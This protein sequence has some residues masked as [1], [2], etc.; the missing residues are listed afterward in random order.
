MIRQLIVTAD[1]YGM[2]ETVNQAIEECLA[3]GVVK[4]TCVMINMP[5]HSQAA[6]LRQRFPYSSL[7]IH[8]TLTEGAPIL[9]PEHL[10]S[11][12]G[13]DGHFRSALELRRRW[14]RGQ[15]QVAEVRAELQAQYQ[16]FYTVVGQPDFWN[17]HQNFHVWPRLFDVC[18]GV[19]QELCIPAMRCH[20]RFT[21][22]RTTSLFVYHLRHPVPWVKSKIISRWA[23]QA[24]RRGMYMPDGMAHTPGYVPNQ[25][26]LV[27]IMQRLPWQSIERAIELLIHPSTTSQEE[28]FHGYGDR[29]VHEYRMFTDPHLFERLTQAGVEP[30]G[31]QALHNGHKPARAD[32]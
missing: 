22:P 29:R 26:T 21:V 14:V 17:T 20:R 11:L 5:A 4:A 18:I 13:L 7:G 9:P 8:W 30:V 23:R 3:V 28:L 12:V 6:S 15:I 16:R 25:T 19:A 2:Y 24:Q 1:D 27:E 31:F 10:P 32:I